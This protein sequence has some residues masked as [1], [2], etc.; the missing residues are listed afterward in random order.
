M[1]DNTEG[2]GVRHS[3]RL[4]PFALSPLHDQAMLDF[5]YSIF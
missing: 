1:F 2:N 3:G 4:L 5:V